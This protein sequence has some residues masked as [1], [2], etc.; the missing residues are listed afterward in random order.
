MQ[1]QKH[2]PRGKPSTDKASKHGHSASFL[3]YD[4]IGFAKSREIWDS[5]VYSTAQRAY[6]GQPLIIT[7]ST[8]G[9]DLQGVGR[10]LYEYACKVRDWTP[11]SHYD[12]D[13][14]FLPVIYES[15]PEDDFRLEATW[16]KANPS[17]FAWSDWQ[18]VVRE[19]ETDGRKLSNA[20][21]LR[22]NQ[23]VGVESAFLPAHQWDA[24][25]K[26]L[27]DL[28]GEAAH[29]GIDLSRERDTTSKLA[30]NCQPWP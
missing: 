16:Q 25:I 15:L 1:K 18:E 6:K 26:P 4:E 13:L 12:P 21:T 24:C 2:S 19:C 20:L 14:S 7:I 30:A 22:L 27:P 17:P 9:Y 28:T 5:F 3:V 29:T 11:E 8:A 23:W 10:E